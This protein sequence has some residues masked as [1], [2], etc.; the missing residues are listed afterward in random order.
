MMQRSLRMLFLIASLAYPGR[1]LAQEPQGVIEHLEIAMWPEY[2]RPSVLVIYRFQLSPEGTLPMTVTLPIPAEAGEPHAVAWRDEAGR[3]LVADYT[4][5]PAGDWVNVSIRMES[6]VG[7]LEYYSDLEFAGSSRSFNVAWPGDVTVG[8]LTYEIQQPVGADG[9]QVDPAPQGQSIGQDGLLY[10]RGELSGA[11]P[12]SIRTLYQKNSDELSAEIPALVQPEVGLAQNPILPWAIGGVGLALLA[13]G[14][15]LYLRL[16]RSQ[17][18]SPVR[19]RRSRG[20][21]AESQ[22]EIDASPVYCHNCGTHAA[23]SD[24]YCRQCGTKLRQ[25]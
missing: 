17:T 15:F 7:Q 18:P 24:V 12:V 20:K 8:S 4:Q 14:G 16:S 9:M 3:L 19:R 6:R 11:G 1:A 10:L 2:D 22:V 25:R 13:V 23:P 21:A 5:E